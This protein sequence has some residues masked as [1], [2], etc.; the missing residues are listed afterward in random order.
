GIY[1]QYLDGDTVPASDCVASFAMHGIM[2]GRRGCAGQGHECSNA[3]QDFSNRHELSLRTE[4]TTNSVRRS[5]AAKLIVPR[6]FLT[7]NLFWSPLSSR[8]RGAAG[9]GR[10]SDQFRTLRSLILDRAANIQREQAHLQRDQGPRLRVPGPGN[11][12]H[13]AHDEPPESRFA[14]RLLLRR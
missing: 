8:E 12:Q 13:I 11:P 2:R 4:V 1:G 3:G 10:A 14:P 6:K 5:I 7:A 9:I